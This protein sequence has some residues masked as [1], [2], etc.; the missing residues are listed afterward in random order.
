MDAIK[1]FVEN[2]GRA[3][4]MADPPLKFSKEQTDDNEPL[5]KVL[6]GWGVTVDKD[7]VLDTSG[8]GELFQ[9]GPEVPL[10]S[11]YQDPHAIVRDMKDTPTGFPIA[12]SLDVKNTDKTTVQ[13]LFETTD[14]SFATTK[15]H[16]G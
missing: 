3:L 2:G 11:G 14:N 15:S 10:V 5:M 4:I 9:M 16:F 6:E 13:K 7:L 1:N 12:R 8:I